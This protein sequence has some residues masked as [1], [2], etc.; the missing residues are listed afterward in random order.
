VMTALQ[1]ETD[2]AQVT[3]HRDVTRKP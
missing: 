2:V 1:A 3:R